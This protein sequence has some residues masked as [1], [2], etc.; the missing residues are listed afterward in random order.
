MIDGIKC[1]C[2]GKD[3]L[4]ITSTL[5]ACKFCDAEWG[6]VN[7]YWV[8]SRAPRCLGCGGDGLTAQE[9]PVTCPECNG[10]GRRTRNAEDGSKLLLISQVF[11]H[12]SNGKRQNP[13]NSLIQIGKILGEP[14]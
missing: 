12:W 2:C 11:N 1:T 4:V 7:G 9:D 3:T 10:T 8:E 14:F 5:I 13:E 6:R